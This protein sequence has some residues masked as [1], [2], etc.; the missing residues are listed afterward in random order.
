MISCIVLCIDSFQKIS[1]S[2]LIHNFSDRFPSVTGNAYQIPE[3]ILKELTSAKLRDIINNAIF[4]EALKADY[5]FLGIGALSREVNDDFTAGFNSLVEKLSCYR[6]FKE[7][8]CCGEISY[9]PV[10]DEMYGSNFLVDK[11]DDS[12]FNNTKYF[13]RVYTIDFQKIIERRKA[14]I[15]NGKVIAVAGGKNKEQAISVCLNMD[16]F[17]EV[18]IT[19]T[20]TAERI[21]ARNRQIAA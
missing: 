19:D 8:G 14:N 10:T 2:V 6:L 5:F 15:L 7:M 16:D 9:C 3:G 1:P 18:L 17:I 13:E 21:I 11:K 4:N 12:D 20:E